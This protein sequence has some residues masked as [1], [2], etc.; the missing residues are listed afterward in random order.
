[1]AGMGQ[2]QRGHPFDGAFQ[3]L[4]AN[5]HD[6]HGGYHEQQHDDHSHH[7]QSH[8]RSKTAPQCGQVSTKRAAIAG[9]NRNP[10]IQTPLAG[11]RVSNGEHKHRHQWHE[12]EQQRERE[13]NRLDHALLAH[14]GGTQ[15]RG[16]CFSMI[17]CH[18]PAF[19]STAW[20][21]IITRATTMI[22][23]KASTCANPC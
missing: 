18:C 9:E 16:H 4:G 2:R 20:L 23:A 15:L 1:M 8:G 3:L 22:I 14:A 12:Q 13:N 19:F 21:S 6:H 10:R 11:K 7:T 17:H 5:V